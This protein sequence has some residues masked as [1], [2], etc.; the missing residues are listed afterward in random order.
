MDV[1]SAVWD[2]SEIK[3]V[4]S[5][6]YEKCLLSLIVR[7]NLDSSFNHSSPNLC[8]RGELSTTGIRFVSEYSFLSSY[9]LLPALGLF[10]TICC[11]HLVNVLHLLQF[12]L[13]HLYRGFVFHWVG[14]QMVEM[15]RFS[16]LD[17]VWT[18]YNSYIK[19]R[20][21]FR[22]TE[23]DLAKVKGFLSYN[24]SEDIE[25]FVISREH[26]TDTVNVHK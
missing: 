7:R 15:L 18:M 8:V 23:S 16:Y 20:Y 13:L 4:T 24:L 22:I 10:R 17:N 1:V 11:F 6:L 9:C 21:N 12:L 5:L 26:I 2:S 19:K 3:H 25:E 14:S